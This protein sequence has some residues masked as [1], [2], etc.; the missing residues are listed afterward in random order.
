MAKSQVRLAF[1]TMLWRVT[2]G[3][4]M[5]IEI[6]IAVQ[7][8]RRVRGGAP[9]FLL[10]LANSPAAIVV[11]LAIAA[12]LTVATDLFVRFLLQPMVDT[13]HR[14]RVEP[15]HGGFHL[16]AREKLIE[17]IPARLRAGFLWKTGTLALT[18]RRLWFFP[19]AWDA[20]P[21]SNPHDQRGWLS[22]DPSPSWLGGL[23]RGLPDRLVIGPDPEHRTTF[24]LADAEELAKQLRRLEPVSSTV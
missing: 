1:G 15:N 6:S 20:E 2:L 10:L 17:S 11:S 13:W 3:L 22:L 5:L 16:E 21:W 8:F 12:G 24:A 19:E 14:P 9:R 23:V 4:F 18:D 7:I